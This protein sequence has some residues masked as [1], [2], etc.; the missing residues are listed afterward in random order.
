[1]NKV[2]CVHPDFSRTF[3]IVEF[4]SLPVEKINEYRSFLFC[5][6][7]GAVSFYRRRTV[8]GKSACFGSRYHASGCLELSRQYIRKTPEM[9]LLRRAI[10]HNGSITLPFGSKINKVESQ[11]EYDKKYNPVS[12]ERVGC[13]YICSPEDM[14]SLLLSG[15][16]INSS[17]STVYLGS[18]FSWKA[19]NL[20]VNIDS[21]QPSDKPKVFW[22]VI[23]HINK[24]QQWINISGRNDVGIPV[25]P[26]REALLKRY[27]IEDLLSCVNMGVLVFGKC[28]SNK[29]KDRLII[30]P[31]DDNESNIHLA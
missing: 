22:G 17:N 30:K 15:D 29:N 2:F 23:S 12:F 3:S 21:A 10:K 11:R 9:E 18:G 1:M 24:T 25:G 16:E 27:G 8:D 19:R 5:L 31:W 14:L 20:F 26:Y 13:A 4:E 28:F 6:E 7:C